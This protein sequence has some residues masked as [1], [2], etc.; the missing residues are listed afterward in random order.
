MI[1]I[2]EICSEKLHE[3]EKYEL[4]SREEN[5]YTSL[6]KTTHGTVIKLYYG[7]L[8]DHEAVARDRETLYSLLQSNCHFPKQFIMPMRIY[9][10]D[11]KI[12]GYEMPFCEGKVLSEA[13]KFAGIGDAVRWFSK[14][15]EDIL[16][17]STLHPSFSFAD[18]HEENIFINT[19]GE[20]FHCDIDGWRSQS[21]CGKRSRY[22]SMS[23]DLYENHPRKYKQ[24]QNRNYFLTDRNSD[25]YCLNIMVMNYLM[26]NGQWFVNL[27]NNDAFLYLDYLETAGLPKG[28]VQMI[29]TLFEPT[30]NFF[31]TQAMKNLPN[32][33]MCFSYESYFSSTE[34]FSSN[35]QALDYLDKFAF[36]WKNHAYYS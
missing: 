31:S 10:F 6:F 17:L 12:V 23:Q 27:Q 22:L 29:N 20:L 2:E 4:L 15:Y 33:I 5:A 34:R 18:L 11:K 35:A 25:I 30:D 19:K 13:L 28:I 7:C 9:T 26:K 32:D 14:I 8:T 21:G 1:R 3:M 24:E 36:K 16:W